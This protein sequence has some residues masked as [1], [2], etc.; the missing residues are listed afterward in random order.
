MESKLTEGKAFKKHAVK[1]KELTWEAKKEII[2]RITKN[3]DLSLIVCAQL[4]TPQEKRMMQRKLNINQVKF[5]KAE[6]TAAMK[7]RTQMINSTK[8]FQTETTDLLKKGKKFGK[9]LTSLHRF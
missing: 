8:Q 7:H 1:G 9:K 2:D 5:Q 6:E 3:H 4:M